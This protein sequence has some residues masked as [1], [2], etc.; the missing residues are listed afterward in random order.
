MQSSHP[1]NRTKAGA[2]FLSLSILAV[3]L[4]GIVAGTGGVSSTQAAEECQNFPQTG[5]EVCGT[6][7]AY[8]R[9]NGGLTQQGFPI[10]RVFDEKN[11]DPPSGDGKVHKVQYFQRARFE[12][13]LE[14]QPPYNVLLGLLGSEQYTSKYPTEPDQDATY[15]PRS[16]CDL[17]PAT[18]NKVCGRFLEYWKANGGLAQQ[19]YPISTVFME[20]NAPP[21]AGD[22]KIHRVQYFQRARFE[23][24]TENARPYDVLLGL[25]GAEQ[26][27]LKYG[28]NPIPTPTPTPKPTPL[29]TTPPTNNT[30]SCNTLQPPAS[31]NLSIDASLLF[32]QAAGG[33]Q[34]LCVTANRNGQPVAGA[35][36][37]YV[38]RYK[39]TNKTFQG[40]DT[41]AQG[42]SSSSWDIGSPS[43]GFEIK[44]DMTVTANGETSLKTVSW[45][46]N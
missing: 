19:G 35:K 34:T 28:A 26:Y 17:F 16:D 45:T 38:V 7:L 30:G 37:T 41:D 8:W 39:S 42:N 3:V 20:Q 4:L 18:G 21:P 46:P 10:S 13:H 24:H 33:Q 43:K 36:I 40:N 1:S 23:E 22:G 12:E 15:Y 11:A 14:N 6:F 9:T 31:P 44:V 29:P 27:N 32:P 2:G 25:L 5:F